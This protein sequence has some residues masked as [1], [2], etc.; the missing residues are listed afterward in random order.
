MPIPPRPISRTIWKSPK[1]LAAAARAA[2]QPGQMARQGTG[3]LR[4]LMH[5][6]QAFETLEQCIGQVGIALQPLAAIRPPAR[7]Q[8]LQVLV[9]GL[10]QPRI[11]RDRIARRASATA[12]ATASDLRK[13]V[14]ERGS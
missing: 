1:G 7:F 5:K 9:H 13:D 10:Q 2:G 11:V 12:S 14:P 4:S 6:L 8:F 3:Q